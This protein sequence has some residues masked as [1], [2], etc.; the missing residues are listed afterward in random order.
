MNRER[1][2]IIQSKPFTFLLIISPILSTYKLVGMSFGMFSLLIFAVLIVIGDP[3]SRLKFPKY[4]LVFFGFMILTRFLYATEVSPSALVSLGLMTFGIVLGF[5]GRY[6]SLKYG[7]KIYRIVALCCCVFFFIQETQFLLYG[8]RSVGILDILPLDIYSDQSYIEVISRLSYAPRA[9]SF[10]SE[11]SYFSEFLLPL[12]AIELFNSNSRNKINLYVVLIT[13][14][15]L[16]LQSGLGLLLMCLIWVIW[17]FYALK[18]SSLYYKIIII[19]VLIPFVSIGTFYFIESEIGKNV[20]ERTEEIGVVDSTTSTYVRIV[21]GYDLFAKYPRFKQVFG[22]N[23]SDKI[24]AAISNS[25]MSNLFQKDDLSFNG[26]QSILLYGGIVG[27][28]LFLLHFSYL[29]KMNGIEGRM[30]GVVFIG[31]SLIAAT[32]LKPSMLICYAFMYSYHKEYLCS[33]KAKN[34]TVIPK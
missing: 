4:F 22:L 26:I 7:V 23:S 33:F 8:S 14:V 24:K 13:V 3:K 11:P 9:A 32:Y 12:L 18:N 5:S 17:F 25:D 19:F 15:L 21:R 27:F 31:L 34:V 28:L 6:F 29:F 1:K 30:I 2:Y 10:F 20:L 16:L